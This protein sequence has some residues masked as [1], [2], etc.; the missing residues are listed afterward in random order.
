VKDDKGAEGSISKT[1]YVK[2]SANKPPILTLYEPQ[3]IGLTVT[4]NG[5]AKPGHTGVSIGTWLYFDWGDGSSEYHYWFPATHTYK[6]AGTY[7]ITVRVAQSDGLTTTSTVKVSVGKCGL[8]PG[9]VLGIFSDKALT[10]IIITD[11]SGCAKQA[12]RAYRIQLTV[13]NQDNLKYDELK[14][15]FSKPFEKKLLAC[16]VKEIIPTPSGIGMGKIL[17]YIFGAVASGIKLSIKATSVLTCTISPD[18]TLPIKSRTQDILLP[19]SGE[20]YLLAY[21]SIENDKRIV[22]VS[23]KVKIEVSDD[24]PVENVV[25]SLHPALTVLVPPTITVSNGQEIDFPVTIYNNLP[26]TEQVYFP[27]ISYPKDALEISLK[28]SDYYR[29]MYSRDI[30]PGGSLSITYTLKPLKKGTYYIRVSIYGNFPYSAASEE[31][32]V[33]VISS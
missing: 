3:I 19:E 29:Y 30:P 21:K 33:K 6:N 17:E 27:S 25:L 20:F 4:I 16:T 12:Q 7:T 13:N 15:L 22:G 11:S 8:P 32:V 2:A 23:Q 10:P 26:L 28:L 14:L 1:M 31:K 24:M 18:Y 9:A 5:D